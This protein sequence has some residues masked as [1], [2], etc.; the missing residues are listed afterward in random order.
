MPVMTSV[1]FATMPI[2]LGLFDTQSKEQVSDQ[3]LT[4]NNHNHSSYRLSV[5]HNGTKN[6]LHL[7]LPVQRGS[8]KSKVDLGADKGAERSRVDWSGAI[9][10]IVSASFHF[11]SAL[12]VIK[13]EAVSV[14]QSVR[15]LKSLFKL[16]VMN[17]TLL[18]L[19]SN[20]RL[21]LSLTLSKS[22]RAPS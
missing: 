16:L 11:L 4:R 15:L 21:S 20:S 2:P 6:C 18:S 22:T 12:P 9:S 10:S 5:G 3:F 13:E 14:F 7:P 1:G 19:S 8:V 17:D